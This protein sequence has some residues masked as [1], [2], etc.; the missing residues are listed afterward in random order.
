MGPALLHCLALGSHEAA[1]E[2]VPPLG[3]AKAIRLQCNGIP[4]SVPA[5]SM[6]VVAR[7]GLSPSWPRHSTYAWSWKPLGVV[8]I[9]HAEGMCQLL[10]VTRSTYPLASH[11]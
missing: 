4:L 1:A 6:L 9:E 7:V 5:C 10:P 11:S 8:D 2:S 3:P